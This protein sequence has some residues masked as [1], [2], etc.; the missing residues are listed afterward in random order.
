LSGPAREG[1]AL[2][3]GL[4]ICGKCGLRLTVR[5]RGNG[6]LYPI[7]ECNRRQRDGTA[8]SGCMTVRCVRLDA[9]VS[10]RLL[11]VLQPAEIEIALAAVRDLEERD[12]AT[13]RQWKMRLERAEYEA[14][15][16]QRRY[17]EVDPSNRLV[18]STLERGWEDALKKLEELK[19]QF[20]DFQR[21]ETRIASPEEKARVLAL[22]KDF[23]RLWN[24][25]TTTA[26]D[27]K[28]ML[29]LLIKDRPA[30]VPTSRERLLREWFARNGKPSWYRRPG[31]P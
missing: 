17:E 12:E 8:H 20:A 28:R 31:N 11:E 5:Y 30:S 3:Q 4:C 21:K 26:K 1:L 18:A 9:A 16:A 7:Y 25:P 22:A 23:P 27:R 13:C 15:L 29:R 2:L 6:G 24:A 19:I 14:Q 10:K